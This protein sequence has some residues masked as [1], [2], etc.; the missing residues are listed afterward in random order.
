[1][2]S[3]SCYSRLIDYIAGGNP[4]LAAALVISSCTTSLTRFLPLFVL[5]Y[6]TSLFLFPLLARPP[7]PLPLFTI[8]RLMNNAT[9]GEVLEAK[10]KPGERKEGNAFRYC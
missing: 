9:I 6:H 2:H 3:V 5:L 7:L 8:S 4:Y 10:T 1:M